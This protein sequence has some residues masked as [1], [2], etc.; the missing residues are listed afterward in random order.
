MPGVYQGKDFDVAGFSVGIVDRDQIIDGS[1]VSYG[2]KLIGIASSGFHSNGYSL[3]R[4]V[5]K[6]QKL[7]LNSKP[8]FS[9]ETLGQLLLK[10]T[11]IYV[12]AVLNI[13]KHY[14]IH[15]M[16]HITGGGLVENMPRVLPKQ[17]MAQID[18]KAWQVP[19]IFKYIQSQGDIPEDEM[20]RVF[21]MG[22]GYV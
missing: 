21:N 4:N 10:P 5:I 7:D 3:V 22:I 2:N 14:P 9:D 20:W 11:Q 12:N 6:K 16:S 17:C 15:A 18:T 13:I 8:D 1:H 19:E